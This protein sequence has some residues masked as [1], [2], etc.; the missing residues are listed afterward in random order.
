MRIRQASVPPAGAS[1]AVAVRVVAAGKAARTVGARV[2]ADW[3]GAA[4]MVAG[5]M[6][7]ASRVEAAQGLAAQAE[8][9]RVAARIRVRAHTPLVR[10][11]QQ[12]SRI[13]L[14]IGYMGR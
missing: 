13:G 9:A 4:R 8:P 7:V 11:T 12:L 14:E 6:R 5:S 1:R 10:C 2:M 3:A